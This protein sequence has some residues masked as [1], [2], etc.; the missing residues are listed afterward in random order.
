[1]PCLNAVFNAMKYEDIWERY[2]KDFCTPKLS[3]GAKSTP[4]RMPVEQF[5]ITDKSS[6]MERRT[7]DLHVCVRLHDFDKESLTL[8]RFRDALNSYQARE[9]CGSIIT[10]LQKPVVLFE[11]VIN[12]MYNDLLEMSMAEKT[13]DVNNVVKDMSSN[14]LQMVFIY[15]NR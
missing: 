10:T 4:K 5:L 11:L 8:T 1:M 13:S 9:P 6:S 12:G 15:F 7:A 14:Y 3:L 2:V